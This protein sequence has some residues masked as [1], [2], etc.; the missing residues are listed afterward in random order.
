M[1]L[2]TLILKDKLGLNDEEVLEQKR[3][4]VY[5]QHLTGREV[6]FLLH[7]LIFSR[8]CFFNDSTSSLQYLRPRELNIEFMAFSSSKM[9]EKELVGC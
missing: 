7:A 4:Y 1:V 9:K 8:Y 3:E 5:M 6:L 2:G